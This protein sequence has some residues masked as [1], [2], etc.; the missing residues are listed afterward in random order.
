MVDL[1]LDLECGHKSSLSDDLA[2]T[3]CQLKGTVVG[4]DVA[5][6]VACTVE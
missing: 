2:A 4:A 3:G 1:P 5:A 6:K